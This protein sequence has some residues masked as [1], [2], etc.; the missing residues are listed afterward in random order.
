MTGQLHAGPPAC[1]DF[2][3]MLV[4]RPEHDDGRRALNQHLDACAECAKLFAAQR[5]FDAQLA[6]VLVA[7]P[8]AW[9][10]TSIL[11]QVTAEPRLAWW[12]QPRV[13]LTLQWSFYAVLSVL[14]L[15]G[16][17]MPTGGGIT[18]WTAVVQSFVAQVAVALDVLIATWA[19]LP[20]DSLIT[21]LD[22]SAWVWE[23]AALALVYLWLKPFNA[24]SRDGTAA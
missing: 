10:T 4:A 20:L 7:E 6:R 15:A 14:L 23:A 17:F 1:G 24:P 11:E 5:S 2:R 18:A 21:I 9:L 16:F 22:D 3:A 12:A 8:P 13:N 19:L